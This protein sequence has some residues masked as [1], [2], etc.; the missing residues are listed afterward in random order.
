MFWSFPFNVLSAYISGNACETHGV[1][2]LVLW[3][4]GRLG[5]RLDDAMSQH[6][7]D[8]IINVINSF[9]FKVLQMVYHT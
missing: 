8:K 6:V 3:R 5:K 2:V 1:F 7:Y 4:I 9:T